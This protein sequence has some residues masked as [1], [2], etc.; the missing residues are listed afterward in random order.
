MKLWQYQFIEFALQNK[1]LKFGEFILKSGRVSP[2]FFNTSYF[3]TG[4]KLAL[5]GRF[6]AKALI[7]SGIYFDVLFGPAYKGISISTATAIALAEYYQQNVSYCFNRKETKTYGEGGSLVG[8]TLKGK[9]MLVDDVI[10]AGTTIHES[11]NIINSYTNTKLV[12][13]LISLDRQERG[14]NI[15]STSQEIEF[16]YGCKIMSII[17]IQDLINYLKNKPNMTSN[18]TKIYFYQKLYGI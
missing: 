9:V 15:F 14:N 5:L 13:I 1:V 2:Y 8:S 16:K 7:D 4:K 18:L 17:T 12:G 11:I 6:Y 10:T 3:D